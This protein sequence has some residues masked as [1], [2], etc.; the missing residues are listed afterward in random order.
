[1]NTP[2]TADQ[3]TKPRATRDRAE[4]LVLVVAFIVFVAQLAAL[5]ISHG[6]SWGGDSYAFLPG[7]AFWFGVGT[8]TVLAFLVMRSTPRPDAR[9]PSTTDTPRAISVIRVVVALIAAGLVF[10]VFRIRHVLL[11]DGIPITTLLPDVHEIHPREPGAMLLQHGFYRL[12]MPVFEHPGA[13]RAMVVQESVAVGSVLAG[14]LF[15]VVARALAREM[16]RSFPAR[17]PENEE[18]L[19][20]ALTLALLS[21]GY[22]QMFFGYVENYAFPV[23]VAALYLMLALR[24]LRGTGS[25]LV[26]LGAAALGVTLSYTGVV[27]GPSVLVLVAAGLLDKVRRRAVTRDLLIATGLTIVLVAWLA[28]GPTHYS[29]VSNLTAMLASGRAGSDYLFSLP[30]IRDFINEHFLLG[31]FGLFLFIPVAIG[32]VSKRARPRASVVFMLVA[33]LS[34]IL[35]CWSVP[36]LPLGYARDWDLFSPLGLV[37]TCAALALTLTLLPGPGARWR[38]AAIIAVVS[39]FHTVPWIALNTSEVRS[40]ERFKTLPLGTGRAEN[41][42]AFWYAQRG[43]LGEAKRW[44]K[45]SLAIEPE[46]SRALDLYGRIAFEE[47]DSRLALQAYLIAVT[48]RPDKADYRQQLAYAVSDVGGPAVA[49]GALD[50]LMVGHEGNGALWLE[51]AMILR[52]CGRDIEAAEAKDRAIRLRPDL[53]AFVDTLP[54]PTTR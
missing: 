11:G 27:L 22:V 31:P 48:L 37:L 16:I 33:G 23:V 53:A 47:H 35:A 39:L 17:E 44:L 46:N 49:L 34:A 30:H 26:P 51:R 21:Q 28:W 5:R 3:G 54:A 10:W 2:A 15:V 18:W 24:F 43:E 45:K 41:T 7:A 42:I 25:I 19:S 52:A 32:L 50:S 6:W 8:M 13:P 20:W 14:I 12:L 1:M 4:L 9:S 29:V 38:T 36:D 40:V